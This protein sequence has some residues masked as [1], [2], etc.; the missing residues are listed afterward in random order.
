MNIY[1]HWT[2]IFTQSGG[3]TTIEFTENVTAKKF[4]MKPF[5]KS[6]LKKQQTQFVEDLKKALEA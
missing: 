6:F 2:G 4:F 5:V 3:K 1:G